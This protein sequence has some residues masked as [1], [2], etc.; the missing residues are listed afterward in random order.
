[1][2]QQEYMNA[3]QVY[4]AFGITRSVL[5]QLAEAGRVTRKTINTGYVSPLN[6]YLVAD[7][8]K[9]LNGGDDGK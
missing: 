4:D 1:M 7:I 3:K 2:N 6:L 9:V 5:G 8:E